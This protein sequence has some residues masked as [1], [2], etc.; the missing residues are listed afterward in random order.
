MHQALRERRRRLLLPQSEL[1][2]S[3]LLLSATPHRPS[4]LPQST[5]FTQS[6]YSVSQFANAAQ[7]ALSVRTIS[8][9]V[10]VVF[11]TEVT[12]AAGIDYQPVQ[13]TLTFQP[14]DTVKTVTVPII[15]AAPNPGEVDVKLYLT[16]QGSAR[17]PSRV[18]SLAI[19][20]RQDIVPPQIVATQLTHQG[21]T[22]TFSKPMNPATVTD[23]RKYAVTERT[24][25][26]GSDVVNFLFLG[27]LPS[28]SKVPLRSVTYDPTTNTATLIPAKRLSVSAQ[29]EVTSSTSRV[30]S[31]ARPRKNALQPIQDMSANLI[32]GVGTFDVPVS[33][34]IWFN[35]LLS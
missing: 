26:K 7:I 10:E 30:L 35:R 1:L 16:E 22:L 8:R 32:G 5:G 24:S 29:Y 18:A 27:K 28:V 19:L 31:T 13:Q 15:P 2:E 34:Q 17:L 9:P 23:V 25:I 21:L 33:R 4:L 11:S 20:N 14:G 3:R 6:E 12:S